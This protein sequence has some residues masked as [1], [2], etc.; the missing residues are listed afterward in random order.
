MNRALCFLL[1][2]VSAFALEPPPTGCIQFNWDKLA[3]KA[4][5]KVDV[6]LEGSILQMASSFL[7]GKGEESK[8]KELV[9][10]LKCVY[11]KSFTF[12]KEGQYSEADL[13]EIRSYARGP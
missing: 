4:A 9:Q 13:N 12:A 3:A 2:N 5:E 11:V 7:G 6:N 1:I 8:V 10:G